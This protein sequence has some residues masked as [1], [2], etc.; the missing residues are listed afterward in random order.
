M[1]RHRLQQPPRR[2]PKLRSRPSQWVWFG[3]IGVLFVFNVYI[4]ARLIYMGSIWVVLPA[5]A[6]AISVGIAIYYGLG[7][8]KWFKS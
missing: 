8:F 3:I 6:M 2:V 1:P 4:S 5:S 7:L